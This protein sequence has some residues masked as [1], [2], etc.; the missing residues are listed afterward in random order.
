MLPQT[1]AMT[2][3]ATP[4]AGRWIGD[5]EIEAY[6]TP[7]LADKYRPPS[8]GG[9]TTVRH[10]HRIIIDGEWYSW[11]AVGAKKWI[12]KG[13]RVTFQYEVTPEGYRNVVPE[14]LR[15]VDKKGKEVIRGVRG[16]AFT[17]RTAAARPPASRRERRD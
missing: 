7:A 15:T 2:N 3:D 5:A 12:F 4:M 11:F 10:R 9:N 13:D 8:R 16:P 6:P 1:D 14:T 17:R